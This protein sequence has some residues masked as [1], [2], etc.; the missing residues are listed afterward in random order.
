MNLIA[1]LCCCHCLSST[2]CS[3][4]TL[5]YPGIVSIVILS[6]APSW[7]PSALQSVRNCLQPSDQLTNS[8]LATERVTVPEHSSFFSVRLTLMLRSLLCKGHCDFHHKMVINWCQDIVPSVMTT[9]F[10]KEN[11]LHH[12]DIAGPC[13][14]EIYKREFLGDNFSNGF[15]LEISE[16]QMDFLWK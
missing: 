2:P 14:D 7:R 6:A 4:L 8:Y 12:Q 10:T 9:I 5:P 1:L 11:S 3:L 13:H 16:L 15:Y